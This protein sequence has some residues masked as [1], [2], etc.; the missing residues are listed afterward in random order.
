MGRWESSY[1]VLTSACQISRGG[2]NQSRAANGL[3]GRLGVGPIVDAG[4][5]G[6]GVGEDPEPDQAPAGA[7]V[8]VPAEQ[9]E[10]RGAEKRPGDDVGQH[11]MHGVAEPRAAERVLD[12]AG[13]D[14]GA[15]GLADGL[16]RRV[17]L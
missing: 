6:R 14:R 11:G 15:H 1:A 17:E 9:V 4:Q 7:T 13:G 8:V 5:G 12:G 16:R 10:Q 2:V 3:V